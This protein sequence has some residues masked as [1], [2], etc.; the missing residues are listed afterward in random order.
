ML[1]P[2]H[3]QNQDILTQAL[4]T[5]CPPPF[6]DCVP[7]ST[8]WTTARTSAYLQTYSHPPS[9]T[10]PHI[11]PQDFSTSGPLLLLPTSQSSVPGPD[12]GKRASPSHYL[13]LCSRIPSARAFLTSCGSSNHNRIFDTVTPSELTSS[14]CLLTPYLSISPRSNASGAGPCLFTHIPSTLQC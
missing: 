12:L 9:G 8:P 6:L 14:L 3:H 11:G 10:V 1:P 7:T 13:A 5:P 4:I 2:D